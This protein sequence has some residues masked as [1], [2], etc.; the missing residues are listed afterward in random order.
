LK[1]FSYL[2]HFTVMAAVNKV[3]PDW[4]YR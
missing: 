4:V 2:A 3:H 1:L